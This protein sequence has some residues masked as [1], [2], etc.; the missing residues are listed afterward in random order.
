MSIVDDFYE[1]VTPKKHIRSI[2][3]KT[4]EIINEATDR[5]YWE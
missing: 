5:D 3:R 2:D 4:N 1:L